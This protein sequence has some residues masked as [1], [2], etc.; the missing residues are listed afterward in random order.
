M[1][2]WVDERMEGRIDEKL[3]GLM[4]GRMD[5]GR[6]RGRKGGWET[7]SEER[8]GVRVRKET[9]GRWKGRGEG[10]FHSFPS[11]LRRV[12]CHAKL[13]T[14][15]SAHWPAYVI[16]E[17]AMLIQTFQI[18]VYWTYGDP[19]RERRPIFTRNIL[20]SARVATQTSSVSF[21]AHL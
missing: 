2:G 10:Q 20:L 8:E 7:V 19:V 16:T 3:D 18:R 6:E 21:S 12:S 13:Q 15:F 5:G 14:I 4:A 9:G 1:D 17:A 11:S